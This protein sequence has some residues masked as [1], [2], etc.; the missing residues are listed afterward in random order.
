VVQEPGGAS[1]ISFGNYEPSPQRVRRAVE[2]KPWGTDEPTEA[3]APQPLMVRPAAAPIPAL[4]IH[5]HLIA[6]TAA[7]PLCMYS[8]WNHAD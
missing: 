5:L 6:P 2:P 1:Q 3:A 8:L 7:K 4:A